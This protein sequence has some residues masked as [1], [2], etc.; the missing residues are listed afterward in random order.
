MN[1]DRGKDS[2]EAEEIQELRERLLVRKEELSVGWKELARFVGLPVG[3]ISPWATGSYNGDNQRVAYHV[4]RYFLADEQR[5]ALEL[6]APIIPGFRNTPTSRKIHAQLRWAQR[7]KIVVITGEAGV[8]KTAAIDQYAATGTNVIKATMSEGT[9][10]PTS[11]LVELLRAMGSPGFRTG[12]MGGVQQ[13]S[14]WVIERV[15][16]RHAL[17]VLDESQYLSDRALNQLRFIHDKCGVGLALAGNTEVMRRIRSGGGRGAA[18]FAQLHSRV[19]MPEHYGAPEQADI[20]I[21][22]EAWEVEH[23]KERAFLS[24]IAAQPGCLRQITMTLEAAT[25]IARQSDEPRTLS[26]LQA[27]WSQQ[28]RKAA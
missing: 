14:Y 23:P 6:E 3:T 15:E 13:L 18:P 27:A 4:N 10:S 16:D 26:H 5:Q 1:I 22:L 9:T 21:I 20:D 25:L 8:G 7:G 11:M 12:G 24:K 19:S 2:F 17:I 28:A